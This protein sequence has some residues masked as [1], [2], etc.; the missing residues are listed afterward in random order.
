MAALDVL[1]D[2]GLDVGEDGV[3]EGSGRDDEQLEMTSTATTPV[4]TRSTAIPLNLPV[5]VV[6]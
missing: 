5:P 3:A 1:A 6:C 2:G 4:S